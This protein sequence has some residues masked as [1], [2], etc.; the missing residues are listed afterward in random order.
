[1]PLP[2]AILSGISALIIVAEK[3][4]TQRGSGEQKKE[5]VMRFIGK[6]YD[7]LK[8]KGKITEE[9]LTREEAMSLISDLIDEFV[10]AALTSI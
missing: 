5:F 1:M 2:I 4:F 10:P 9:L 8:A 3:I 6:A 7:A